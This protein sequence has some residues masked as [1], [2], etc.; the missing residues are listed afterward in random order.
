MVAK[1]PFVCC[2]IRIYLQQTEAQ[3]NGFVWLKIINC[4]FINKI[5]THIIILISTLWTSNSNLYNKVW[6]RFITEWVPVMILSSGFKDHMIRLYIESDI[7]ITIFLSFYHIL[8]KNSPI[9]LKSLFLNSFFQFSNF[10]FNVLICH[11]HKLTHPSI[12]A[13]P[14]DKDCLF[15]KE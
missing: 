13:D 4:L 1:F 8:A 11:T 9:H 6:C 12:I 10:L 5:H 3:C 7:P 2:F 14:S 15:K